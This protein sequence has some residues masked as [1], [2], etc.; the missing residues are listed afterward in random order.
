M[1][2]LRIETNTPTETDK[3]IKNL[4]EKIGNLEQEN[5]KLKQRLNGFTL[6]NEQVQELLQRIEKLEQKAKQDS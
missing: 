1:P 4:E 2:H 5:L 3:T 6:N